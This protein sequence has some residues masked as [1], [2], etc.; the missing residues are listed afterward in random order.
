M[1]TRW[2]HS[3]RPVRAG[4][5]SDHQLWPVSDDLE[6]AILNIFCNWWIWLKPIPSENVTGGTW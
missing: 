3:T 2:K 5:I 1:K 6:P 4:V